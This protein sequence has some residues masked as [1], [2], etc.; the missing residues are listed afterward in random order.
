[1]PDLRNGSASGSAARRRSG[2]AVAEDVPVARGGAGA[3]RQRLTEPGVQV[4]AVVGH[5]VHHH[6]DVCRMRGGGQPVEVVHRAEL[7]IHVTVVGHVVAAVREFARVEGRQPD[8]VDAQ[9]PQ[10]GD[11]PGDAIDVA[12]TG[13]GGVLEAARVDLVDHGL[14]PPQCR[15]D[16]GVVPRRDRLRFLCHVV[17]LAVCMYRCR[18]CA[19]VMA[20]GRP[21]PECPRLYPSRFPRDDDGTAH[22]GY[23]LGLALARDV[24]NRMGARS[25]WSPHPRPALRCC[26]LSRW[27][28][29]ASPVC[30]SL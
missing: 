5:D 30:Y 9:L 22:Q 1:M 28:D 2:L 7:R 16:L 13:A 8:R 18:S 4:G 20:R 6:F 14:P 11:P 25:R 17:L 29:G 21:R 27:P 15:V 3:A 24:A 12:Q 26:S 23:G 10:I 19:A